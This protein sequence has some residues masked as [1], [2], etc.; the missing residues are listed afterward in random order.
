MLT[1]FCNSVIICYDVAK[2]IQYSAVMHTRYCVDVILCTWLINIVVRHVFVF[3]Y[4][5]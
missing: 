4:N 1:Y 2:L 5:Y 3:V